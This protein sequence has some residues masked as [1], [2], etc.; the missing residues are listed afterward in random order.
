[1]IL[2][3]DDWPVARNCFEAITILKS[4]LSA[5]F[6]NR[7]LL[8]GNIC[9]GLEISRTRKVRT[10]KHVQESY[11]KKLLD[12]FKVTDRLQTASIAMDQQT[13]E[14][15]LCTSPI[16][17]R[18]YRQA[19]ESLTYL[20][21]CKWPDICFAVCWLVLYI[22]KPTECWWIAVERAFRYFSGTLSTGIGYAAFSNE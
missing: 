4:R 7:I 20:M 17:D 5:R 19:I 10:L 22:E 13:E 15:N 11:T 8:R 12:R 2:Y 9:L 18:L 3:V 6:E 1:M 14:A 21:I 16:C